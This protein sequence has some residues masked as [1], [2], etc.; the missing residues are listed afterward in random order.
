MRAFRICPFESASFH[1]AS[2][3]SSLIPASFSLA[4]PSRCHLR[5]CNP[6]VWRDHFLFGIHLRRPKCFGWLCCYWLNDGLLCPAEPDVRAL[7]SCDCDRRPGVGGIGGY[8]RI[9]AKMY[10][11]MQSKPTKAARCHPD[12]DDVTCVRNV[13]RCECF[14]IGVGV[15]EW[16]GRACCCH[17]TVVKAN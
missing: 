4:A 15:T 7:E 2:V 3:L 6:S 10:S 8:N 17:L 12:G 13:C 9:M 11:T 5:L 14:L 16:R 1:P